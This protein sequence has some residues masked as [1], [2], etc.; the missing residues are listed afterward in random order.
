MAKKNKL[1]PD[2]LQAIIQEVEEKESYE[3]SGKDVHI[4]VYGAAA[5]GRRHG[6]CQI[7]AGSS[8]PSASGKYGCDDHCKRRGRGTGRLCDGGIAGRM[9]LANPLDT[10][11]GI[12]Y[13]ISD[14]RQ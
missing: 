5:Q 2:E 7:P 10:D 12:A 14:I 9:N 4:Q 3:F 11:A 6:K 1:L 13:N 8:V